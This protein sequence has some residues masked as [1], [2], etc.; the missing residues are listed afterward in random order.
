[1]ARDWLR[2]FIN[3]CVVGILKDVDFSSF[4]HVDV[5]HL[6]W[7]L[8]QLENDCHPAA[9]SDFRDDFEAIRANTETLA[10][11][12]GTILRRLDEMGSKGHV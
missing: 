3:G 5:P 9:N 10:F 1:V 7:Q 11:G 4:P 12:M 6:E 2:Y 8:R